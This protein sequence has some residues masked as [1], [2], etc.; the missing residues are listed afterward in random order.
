MES[1]FPSKLL[2]QVAEV[3]YG[4]NLSD[5]KIWSGHHV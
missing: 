3:S 5:K 4:N 2:P 1:A